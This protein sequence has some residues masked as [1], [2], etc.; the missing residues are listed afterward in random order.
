MSVHHFIINE[1][2]LGALYELLQFMY[3]FKKFMLMYNF[4]G[5]I[6]M[7]VKFITKKQVRILL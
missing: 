5:I 1:N 7:K 3:N 4:H 2:D 6:T